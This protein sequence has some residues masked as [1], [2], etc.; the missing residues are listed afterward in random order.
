MAERTPYKFSV[1]GDTA[2]GSMFVDLLL[3]GEFVATLAE[4]TVDDDA[5]AE[6]QLAWFHN[7]LRRCRRG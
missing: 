3:D 6:R 7:A 1:V 2:N 4:V 5:D